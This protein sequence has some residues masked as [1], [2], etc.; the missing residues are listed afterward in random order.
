MNK[1]YIED[2]DDLRVLLVNTARKKGISEAVI[3]KDYWV[4]FIL[5]YLFNE[6]KWK[7]YFTF[8][9]GTS[10]SKCFGLIE[11]FSEDIDLILDW[12]VLGYEEKEPWIERSNTKQDKF[13][14]EVNEK[15]EVFLRDKFLTVLEQDLKDFNFEFS[16]DIIDPQ[17]ILCKYPKIFE[18]NYLS[19][20]IRLEIGSLA[21]W[22]P[23]IDVDILPII[24]E[25]YPN[26]FKEKT[27]I[28]TVSAE[29]TFWEKATILHHE[30]NRP[31]SSHMPHR[32]ARHFYDLY[33]IANSDFK[34]KALEN[35]D[36]LKKVT[37]FKMKFY[38]RKWAKYE[39]VLDGNLR[40]V[41]DKFRFS[42][43]EKDYKAMSE[44]IYGAYPSFDEIINALKELEKEINK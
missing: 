30:A 36:L 22:T 13:N 6:N 14:K 41:P 1:F 37:E 28:R 15:T 23:A 19:Q 39:N 21:A 42:E 32:Y 38:P 40:L 8:K 20:N 34:N 35:K 5:D 44:M 43:I 24:G 31:E 26:V 7:E 27:K 29:R 25:V 4:T 10:L 9:G 16:I 17:T 12:R 18:S 3:E 11:R 2:K 33:K